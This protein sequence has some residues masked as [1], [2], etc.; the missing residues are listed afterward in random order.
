MLA[1]EFRLVCDDF[2]VAGGFIQYFDVFWIRCMRTLLSKH[3]SNTL[4]DYMYA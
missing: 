4:I 3:L 2:K 1:I